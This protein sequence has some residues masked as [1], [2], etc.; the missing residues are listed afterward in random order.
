MEKCY[1]PT[2]SQAA[3]RSNKEEIKSRATSQT[4]ITVSPKRSIVFRNVSQLTST[5]RPSNN[6]VLTERRHTADTWQ[7]QAAL[8]E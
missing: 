3:D 2:K 1:I 6:S 5:D 4:L 8:Q 7:K